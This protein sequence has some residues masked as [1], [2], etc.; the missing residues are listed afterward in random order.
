MLL[1][2]VFLVAV[3]SKMRERSAL[4]AV[5][6]FLAPSMGP[7]VHALVAVAVLAAEGALAGLLI[8]GLSAEIVLVGVIGFLAVTT[9]ALGVLRMRGYEGGCACFGERS[10]RGTVGWPDLLRN[11]I[12]GAVT[13]AALLLVVASGAETPPL[14]TFPFPG[15]AAA[16]A[17]TASVVLS[18]TML[19]GIL[20]VRSARRSGVS[21]NA[22]GA[23]KQ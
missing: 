15:V 23:A 11:G 2:A 20:A 16:A 9:L 17:V 1:A 22:V 3:Y 6:R 12:L 5:L 14:W 8:V 7:R 19:D 21:R 4:R 10:A 13:V 18:Y